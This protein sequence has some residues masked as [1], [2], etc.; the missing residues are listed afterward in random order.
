MQLIDCHAHRSIHM[1]NN[2]VDRSTWV[3]HD[4]NYFACSIGNIQSISI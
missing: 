3:G 2:S 1:Y 4:S